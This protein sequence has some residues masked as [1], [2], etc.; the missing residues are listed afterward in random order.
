M[1]RTQLAEHSD[2]NFNGHKAAPGLDYVK[3]V[4]MTPEQLDALRPKPVQGVPLIE[5]ASDAQ[6]EVFTSLANAGAPRALAA[7]LSAWI[8]DVLAG[9]ESLREDLKALQKAHA[10]ELAALKGSKK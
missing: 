3:R 6:K 10:A 9:V 8:T 1:E 2:P 4:P 7:V 5:K